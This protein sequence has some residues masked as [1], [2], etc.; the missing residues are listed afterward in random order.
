MTASKPERSILSSRVDAAAGAARVARY[1]EAI[2]QVEGRRA[3]IADVDLPA[4][5][6]RAV[7]AVADEERAADQAEIERLRGEVQHWRDEEAV[8]ARE[9]GRWRVMWDKHGKADLLDRATTAEARLDALVADLRAIHVRVE[10]DGPEEDED[11]RPL[12]PTV[13]YTCETCCDG[14]ADLVTWPCATVAVLDKH[15]GEQAQGGEGRG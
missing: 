3:L 7:V 4:H 2:A 10:Q 13:R 9:L 12:P 14:E 8:T 1:A 6:A 11:G 5:Y 15:A